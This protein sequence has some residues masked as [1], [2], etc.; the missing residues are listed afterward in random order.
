MISEILILRGSVKKKCLGFSV[1]FKRAIKKILKNGKCLTL[2]I[3]AFE[4]IERN[5]L[6]YEANTCLPQSMCQQTAPNFQV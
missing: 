4:V 6:F 5:S 3:S 2:Q 1:A